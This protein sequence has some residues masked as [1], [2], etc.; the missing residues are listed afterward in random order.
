M[1]YTLNSSA[2]IFSFGVPLFLGAGLIFTSPSS[3]RAIYSMKTKNPLNLL[4]L[5][6]LL[7]IIIHSVYQMALVMV[8]FA[9]AAQQ[10]LTAALNPD[11][12]P[13]FL[14]AGILLSIVL[15]PLASAM[16]LWIDDWRWTTVSGICICYVLT[17]VGGP[18]HSPVA[19]PEV[20]LMTPIHLYRAISISLSG[21]VFATP[22]AMVSYIGFFFA[23]ENLIL[24]II[25]Y[26]G[27]AAVSVLIGKIVLPGDINRWHQQRSWVEETGDTGE[28]TVNKQS[29][30]IVAPSGLIGDLGQRRR[31]FAAVL[32]TLV[33]LVPVASYG[34]IAFQYQESEAVIYETP[35]T[36]VVLSLGEWLYGTFEASEPPAGVSRMI[37]YQL[38]ILDWGSAPEE[39]WFVHS[40]CPYT[41][42]E[43]EMM[44][45]TER[46]EA[47]YAGGSLMTRDRTEYDEG[48]WGL[49]GIW[50]TQ[51]WAI[52]FLDSNWNVTAGALQITLRVVLGDKRIS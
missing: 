3:R 27:L 24:P 45:D 13:G 52:R 41:L 7:L 25:F 16:A 11:Y 31:I 40:C 50:G 26:A 20:A 32:V 34:Y 39:M 29:E 14:V 44:N 47:G 19:Y 30:T 12:L 48:W 49:S 37:S 5:R 6:V 36:G 43:F 17:L 38:N 46:E 8:S 22:S 21:I 42:D 10:P 1:I 2:N 15:G 35:G 18:S 51:V 23:T 33:L 9:V 4:L 28:D